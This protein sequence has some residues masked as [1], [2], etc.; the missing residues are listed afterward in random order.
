MNPGVDAD[1]AQAGRTDVRQPHGCDVLIAD[2]AGASRELLTAI[3]RNLEGRMSIEAARDGH[4]AVALWL[5]LRPRVTL[6][7][8]DMPGLD[9]LTVLEQLRSVDGEAFVAIVSGSN[10]IDNVKRALSLGAAGFVIKPYKPQRIV[11]LLQRYHERSGHN[12]MS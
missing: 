7:D 8:I 11:D 4:E 12:L 9:G 10:S 2:D 1:P 6:L 3:L 5:A